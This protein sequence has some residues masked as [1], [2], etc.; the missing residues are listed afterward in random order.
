[1]AEAIELKAWARGR[2]GKGGARAERREGRVPGTLYGD[3]KEPETISVD[4]RAI[5]HQL[6]TGHFQSTIYVLDV[7]GKK[8]RVIPRAVQLDPVR[9]FPIH[10]DFLRLG[11][12]ALVT[13]EVPV[14]FLNEA[15]SP[16]LKRGGVLNIVRHEIQVRCPSDAIPD[17]FDIDL[18]GLEIGDAVHIS[19]LKLPEG[20]KP[21]ITERDFTVA[22]IVG[23]A[24]EEPVAGAAAAEAAV[25]GTEGAE[26]AEGAA[27]AETGEDKDKDKEKPKEREKKK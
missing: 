13:V 12:D 10:V 4:Y 2:S 25:P 20:V 1:M 18:T 17:H 11:K 5:N 7:D 27:A 21:T 16:G 19:A 3:K 23:R 24:A 6:H 15:A 14:R 9:D 26:A 22:T 8:T